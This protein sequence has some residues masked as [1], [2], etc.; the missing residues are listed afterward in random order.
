MTIPRPGSRH[1]QAWLALAAACAFPACGNELGASP[2]NADSS[3]LYEPAP[4]LGYADPDKSCFHQPDLTVSAPFQETTSLGFSASDVLALFNAR[5]HGTM[6]WAD[7]SSTQIDFHVEGSA[8]TVRYENYPT[9]MGLCVP[10]L[11]VKGLTLTV[12]SSDS[13]LSKSLSSL[14]GMQELELYAH[15]D[16]HGG[17]GL[18]YLDRVRLA[19]DAIDS[20]LVRA[21]NADHPENDVRFLYMSLDVSDIGRKSTC[22]YGDPL[23][24]DPSD[25]CN[26]YDGVLRYESYPA[27]LWADVHHVDHSRLI[28][29]TLASWT[30]SRPTD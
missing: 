24:S 6:T 8:P 25:E 19:P 17:I 21:A 2:H 7:G 27:D 22:R 26:R 28:E 29:R 30:W 9:G 1:L 23:S 11:T 3:L 4:I 20:A 14:D 5:A 10:N 18:I 16:G 13:L 12:Q 15:S